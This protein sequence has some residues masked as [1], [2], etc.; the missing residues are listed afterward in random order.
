ML[1]IYCL[2]LELQCLVRVCGIP[3]AFT[4]FSDMTFSVTLNDCAK[5]VFRICTVV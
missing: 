2:T 5:C 1:S 3:G 4:V